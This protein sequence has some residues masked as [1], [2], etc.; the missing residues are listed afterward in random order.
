MI[1]KNEYLKKFSTLQQ[2]THKIGL[3]ATMHIQGSAG[4]SAQNVFCSNTFKNKVFNLIL[5]LL[6]HKS[7]TEK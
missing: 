1:E 3:S 7:F 4:K 6:D 5:F 2:D